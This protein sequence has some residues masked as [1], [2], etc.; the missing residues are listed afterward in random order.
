MN[1]GDYIKEKLSIW[2]V[3]LSDE[4]IQIELAKVNLDSSEAITGESNTDEFFYNVI[5][6]ILSTPK[7]VSE[8]G[9][10][11]SYDKDAM[12]MYFKMIASKLGKRD[13][14]NSNTITDISNR[15]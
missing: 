3:S 11:V 9:Y 15:W 2:S 14:L 6:Y 4:L 8:G 1:I 7:S 13:F 12:L 5:P 10:S